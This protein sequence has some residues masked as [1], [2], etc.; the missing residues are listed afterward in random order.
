MQKTSRFIL[1]AALLAGCATQKPASTATAESTLIP[2]GKIWAS[3]FQ[4][5]AAEYKALCLQA[6]N[7]AQLRL[8]LA[9]QQPHNRPLAVVTDIDET[10]L[11]NSP[12]D[13]KQALQ[14]KDY[15]TDS[16]HGWTQLGQAD[17]LAGALSFFKY[18]AANQVAV[19]YITNRDETER[20]GTLKN[21]QRYGFPYADNEHLVL[22]QPGAA[23]SKESRRQQV[24]QTHD[25]VLLLGDNLGDFSAL[26]DK[27]SQQERESN[28]L[29]SAAD[30][31]KKFIVLPNAAYGDW[32]NALVQYNRQLTT[33]QKDS[34]IRA[35]LKTY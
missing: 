9:L 5:K 13:A 23:S 17:T 21:L 22:K 30:F 8:Q 35:S 34:V 18:A 16:W 25:I 26:F 6:Y 2:D 19:Y 4:Q 27:K 10:M 7:I 28:V 33:A 12:Y 14:G 1:A 29:S 11:D 32:E 20:E 31:G 24:L 3:L 15:T